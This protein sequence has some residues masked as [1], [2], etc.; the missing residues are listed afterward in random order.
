MNVCRVISLSSPNP[1]LQPV[2]SESKEISSL[3][4]RYH[5]TNCKIGGSFQSKTI[6]DT[7]KVITTRILVW[8]LSTTRNID[9]TLPSVRSKEV[10]SVVRICSTNCVC[11]TN[12]KTIFTIQCD[13]NIT[14][15]STTSKTISLN[16]SSML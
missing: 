11:S 3:T 2:T 8:F 5:C 10:P 6:T 7:S 15:C 9:F 4:T 16:S 13:S 1:S 14:S 12:S